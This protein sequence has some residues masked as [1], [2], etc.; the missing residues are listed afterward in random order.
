MKETRVT[1]GECWHFEAVDTVDPEVGYC[2]CPFPFWTTMPPHVGT[3]KTNKR[4][5]VCPTFRPL[6]AGSHERELAREECR[7]LI[8]E[9]ARKLE[10]AVNPDDDGYGAAIARHEVIGMRKAADLLLHGKEAQQ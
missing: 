7:I 9:A 1:C 3:N 8:E 5:S 4:A 10:I 6:K 2:L